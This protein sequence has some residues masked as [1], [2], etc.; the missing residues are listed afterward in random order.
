MA[1]CRYG[2]T[3][4]VHALIHKMTRRMQRAEP[5]HDAQYDQPEREFNDTVA[6]ERS[7]DRRLASGRRRRDKS[8]C[9]NR[10]IERG[11]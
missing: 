8:W 10:A 5:A 7:R 2:P 6:R 11:E 1:A 9:Q 4:E 3:Y